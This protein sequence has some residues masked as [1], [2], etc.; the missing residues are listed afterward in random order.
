M[1]N[2]ILTIAFLMIAM[3]N[4]AGAGLSATTA[5]QVKNNEF[6]QLMKKI[7]QDF[8]RNPAPE[9]IEKALATYNEADGSFTD[10]DYASIQR[11]NW[12]PLVHVNR[13]Y[14]FAFAYTTPGNKYHEDENL[15][16]QIVKGLEYW[17]ERN[18]RCHNWWYNQ[19]AEPQNLG[20]L[21]IQLRTGKQQI[22]AELESKTLERIRKEGGDPAKWTGA[23]RTD[24]ALHWIYRACLTQN[25]ADLEK[26]LENVYNP[27]VYTTKEGFQYDNCYFQHG[28]Q[29]YIGGYGDEILKGITQVAGYTKGT[30]Y[31]IP[32][33]KLALLSQFMRQ[34]YYATIRGQHMLFDVLGRGVSRPKV[35]DKSHTALFAKRMA[36]LDSDHADEFKAIIA[37]LEGKKP[38]GYALKPTHTHYFRGDYTLHIRPHYTFDVRMVSNRTMR[39]EY[40]NGE[41]LKTY[42]MSDG[43]TNIVTKG[44]E[45]AEIFPVWNWARIPGVTAPQL[46]EI[47]KAASDWQ[48]PGTSTFAGGVSDSLYGVST[49]YYKDNYAGINTGARKSWFFFDEEVVCLGADIHSTAEAEVNTTVN[50]CLSAQEKRVIVCS[51]GKPAEL[52]PGCSTYHSPDWVLH[53]GVAYLFPDNEEVFVARQTQSGNWYDINQTATKEMQQKEVFTL[54]INHGK[55]PSGDTY[56]YLVVPGKTSAK[57]VEKYRK[58]GNIEIAANTAEMQVVRHKESGIWGMVF[59]KAGTFRH[60]DIR[61]TVDKPCV[62]MVKRDDKQTA[63]LHIADPG[64]TESDIQV[65]LSLPGVSEKSQ[66]LVCSFKGSGIYAGATKAYNVR[67]Q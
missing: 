10:V 42:F 57:A 51:D 45:Y 19:I 24:I 32:Q 63:S 60:Q 33:E 48:T 16:K 65:S 28:R 54:G 47:P 13:L 14:D 18:P 62:L 1:K 12:P 21:L 2:R 36:E 27:I 41:N 15:F 31:A 26:A 17:Y 3:C 44:D 39:C 9:K 52:S 8:A 4:F 37:R 34:T 43:C 6:E 61:V 35:T 38:A 58:K 66:T 7:R 22:P 23:N 56:A 64:Q 49:Y 25:E 20:I 29:L 40:G 67:L 5:P 11:T 59:H 55:R 53:N 30:R 50:Q 46:K